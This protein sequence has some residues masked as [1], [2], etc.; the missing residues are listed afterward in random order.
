[1]ID[2]LER[3]VEG[4]SRHIEDISTLGSIYRINMVLRPPMGVPN[5]ILT[6]FKATTLTWGPRPRGHFGRTKGSLVPCLVAARAVHW[7]PRP[8]GTRQYV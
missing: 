5:D 3:A 8:A 6:T 1:M 7:R 4:S 2:I